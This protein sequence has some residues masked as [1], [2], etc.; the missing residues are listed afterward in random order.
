MKFFVM[1]LSVMVISSFM[2]SMTHADCDFDGIIQKY[3]NPRSIALMSLDDQRNTVIVEVNKFSHEP[4]PQLQGKS[5]CELREMVEEH[6]GF[7]Y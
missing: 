6:Y 3:R 1:I 7:D 4:I 2:L 5:N